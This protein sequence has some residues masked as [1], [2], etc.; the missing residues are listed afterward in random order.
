MLL[1]KKEKCNDCKFFGRPKT[2]G[3]KGIIGTCWRKTGVEKDG[4]YEDDGCK[5]FKAI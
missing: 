1:V 2:V 4:K 3:K 5:F